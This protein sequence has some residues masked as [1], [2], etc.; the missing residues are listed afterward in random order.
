MEIFK[1]LDFDASNQWIFY[2]ERFHKFFDFFANNITDANI[3]LETEVL[4]HEEYVKRNEYLDPKERK[5]H[6]DELERE[7]VG[8]L[9]HTKDEIDNLQQEYE[10]MEDLYN[11]YNELVEDMRYKSKYTYYLCT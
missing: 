6:L 10:I 3:L 2:D 8:L 5:P 11:N 9:T 4:D 7:Y 1:K